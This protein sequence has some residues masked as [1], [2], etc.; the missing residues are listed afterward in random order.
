[1]FYFS[2]LEFLH[3]ITFFKNKL[4]LSPETMKTGRNRK[5]I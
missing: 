1:M 4:K 3:L 5:A 2:E